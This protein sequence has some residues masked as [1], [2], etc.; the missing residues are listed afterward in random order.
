MSGLP[1]LPPPYS[2]PD[3]SR[4]VKEEEEE[5]EE[6]A[7]VTEVKVQP[8]DPPPSSTPNG[9]GPDQSRCVKEEEVGGPKTEV[10]V[11]PLDPPA[12]SVA[13]EEPDSLYVKYLCDRDIS[14]T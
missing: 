6:G 12:V 13:T 14:H 11:E 10:K 2:T 4:C 3:Q 9:P 7:P 1:D 8:L 5:E